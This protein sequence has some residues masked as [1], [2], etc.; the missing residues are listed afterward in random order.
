MKKSVIAKPPVNCHE[1]IKIYVAEV[2]MSLLERLQDDK[3]IVKTGSSEEPKLQAPETP[4]LPMFFKFVG[5]PTR[6]S[7][8]T[9]FAGLTKLTQ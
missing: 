3:F 2:F 7:V 4:F 1:T 9:V 8:N 6:A 5:N